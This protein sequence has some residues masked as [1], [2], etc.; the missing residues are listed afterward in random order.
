VS[1]SLPYY[2]N[3]F[4]LLLDLVRQQKVPITELALAPLTAQYLD[5]M[6]QAE[7]LDVNLGMEFAYTAAIL[8]HL[9]SKVLVPDDPAIVQRQADSRAEFIRQLLTY[10]E[11]CQ[12]AAILQERK[13]LEDAIY[14]P[15]PVLAPSDSSDSGPQF[16]S[17]WEL[18]EEFQV[19]AR[20]DWNPQPVYA[21]ADEGPDIS[22]MMEWLQI[23][24]SGIRS[25]SLDQLLLEQVGRSHQAA[26][27]LAV[28]ENA[29]RGGI[30]LEQTE[31]FSSVSITCPQ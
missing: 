12:A 2:E 14:T 17:L 23:R 11:T 16:F 18:L 21:P 29:R 4:D 28:L 13:E 22:E 10:K 8:I 24:L 6:H 26:L 31:P 30:S 15:Q 19:L 7:R 1:D 25:I 27:F 9:K 5:Y 3:P 20:L